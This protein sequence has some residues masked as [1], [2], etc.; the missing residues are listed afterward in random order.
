[1]SIFD[2]I[3]INI[4][5]VIADTLQPISDVCE[6]GLRRRLCLYSRVMSVG[7]QRLRKKMC[8]LIPVRCDTPP[9]APCP[10]QAPPFATVDLGLIMQL[11]GCNTTVS[12]IKSLHRRSRLKW[13]RS[14]DKRQRASVIYRNQSKSRRRS[15][16]FLSL[17]LYL[18]ISDLQCDLA[19][20]RFARSDY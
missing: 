11:C 1:V 16:L 14:T 3:L 4:T 18:E 15:D 2:T 9:H 8:T 17:S 20:F 6:C 13:W 5:T 10:N 19:I 7:I 12:M